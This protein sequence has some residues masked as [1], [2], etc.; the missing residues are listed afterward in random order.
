MDLT[1]RVAL[2]T[3]AGRRVGQAIAEAIGAAGA[4]VAIHY[5]RSDAG[6]QALAQRLAGAVAF[7]ADLRDAHAAQDLPGR[8]AADM[9]RLDILV[10]SASV[11]ER[12]VFG[13]VSPEEWDAVMQ[14]NLRAYFFT[15]QGAAPELRRRH[16]QI[17]NISD[18]SARQPWPGYL[19]HSASKAA[20]EHLTRGLAVV[21]APEVRVNAVAPGAVLLPDAW[22]AER[23][24]AIVRTTPLGRLGSPTDVAGAVRYLLGAEFTTGTTLTVDGGRYLMPR[25]E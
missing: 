17:V 22:G 6:A 20:V 3:G 15:A 1:G 5:H 25:G 7:Q 4:R 21:L 8:V 16:G 14:L 10:N 24:E 11:M 12:Q 9:G 18:M 23:R 19:V 13:S 2:V